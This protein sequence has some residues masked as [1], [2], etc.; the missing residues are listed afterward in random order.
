MEK[1]YQQSSVKNKKLASASARSPLQL[2]YAIA[3]GIEYTNSEG[4]AHHNGEALRAA[5]GYEKI[6]EVLPWQPLHTTLVRE[7]SKAQFT[8][9]KKCLPNL[10]D[11]A[12]DITVA[13]YKLFPATDGTFEAVVQCIDLPPLRHFHDE[14]AS[15]LG[16]KEH[17]PFAQ[18]VTLV[19]VKNGEGART[20]ERV[21]NTYYKDFADCS[22][23]PCY[24]FFNPDGSFEAQTIPVE[25]GY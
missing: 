3:C 17:Y 14:V 20:L 12:G 11:V 4:V 9:V 24:Y 13:D 16:L 22:L 23:A 19:R 5:I 21:K 10:N 7:L 18:H 15:A 8:L 1:D 25:R 6:V 2:G